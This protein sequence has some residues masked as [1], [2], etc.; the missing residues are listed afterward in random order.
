MLFAYMMVLQNN[1]FYKIIVSMIIVSKI[2]SPIEGLSIGLFIFEL[3]VL[4]F[5]VGS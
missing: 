1:P 5:E 2:K 3:P 4:S